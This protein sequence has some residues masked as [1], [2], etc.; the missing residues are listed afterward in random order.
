M[1]LK[2]KDLGNRIMG[3]LY[4]G[5]TWKENRGGGAHNGEGGIDSR[6]E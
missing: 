4:A 1:L 5:I 2:K 3:I 6:A